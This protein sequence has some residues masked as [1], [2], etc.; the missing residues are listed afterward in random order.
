MKTNLVSLAVCHA[1]Q[2]QWCSGLWRSGH[3]F[4]SSPEEAMT[5]VVF[6]HYYK[7]IEVSDENNI[8]K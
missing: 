5:S 1:P 4:N 8:W 6:A 2:N 7:I 3:N